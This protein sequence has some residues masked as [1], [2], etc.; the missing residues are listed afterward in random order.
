MHNVS[1]KPDFNLSSGS[2]RFFSLVSFSLKENITELIELSVS[3]KGRPSL[4]AGIC[5]TLTAGGEVIVRQ[6][7]SGSG[8]SPLPGSY[9]TR[10]AQQI[11]LKRQVP[12]NERKTTM[13]S[14]MHMSSVAEPEIT[15][16]EPGITY[17]YCRAMKDK[18]MA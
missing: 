17:H 10:L 11:L 5:L 8:E 1:L 6:E 7:D 3:G 16:Q 2:V 14:K 9:C 18:D 4:S 12:N 15:I 13:V